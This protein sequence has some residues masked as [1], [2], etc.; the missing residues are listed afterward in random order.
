VNGRCRGQLGQVADQESGAVGEPVFD[1]DLGD[2]ADDARLKLA[3]RALKMQARTSP[4][5][6]SSTGRGRL[7]DRPCENYRRQVSEH[8]FLRG[9]C[10][11]HTCGI[12][13][14]ATPC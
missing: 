14:V 6:Q 13:E 3:E 11:R 2:L 7:S 4:S 1:E 8:I 12:V 10:L 5:A 9:Q